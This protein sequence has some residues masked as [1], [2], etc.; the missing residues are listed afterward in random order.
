MVPMGGRAD[1]RD[2]ESH[3]FSNCDDELCRHAACSVDYLQDLGRP[4]GQR[5]IDRFLAD[6]FGV[7]GRVVGV[8][9]GNRAGECRTRCDV[10]ASADSNLAWT[11]LVALVGHKLY[12]SPKVGGL[13]SGNRCLCSE[14]KVRIFDSFFAKEYEDHITRASSACSRRPNSI[15]S[16]TL[17]VV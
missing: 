16:F 11:A 12:S 15:P 13:N 7:I 10:S 9:L 2:H 8:V 14:R 6:S 4:L 17:T 3:R 5:R 1:N